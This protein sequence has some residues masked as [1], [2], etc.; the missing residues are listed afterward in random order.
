M[1]LPLL[2]LISSQVIELILATDLLPIYADWSLYT[3]EL[4][5][6][7][8]NGDRASCFNH[9]GTRILTDNSKARQQ[10]IL[11]TPYDANGG[12]TYEWTFPGTTPSN[13]I[14]W[15]ISFSKDGTKF[16]N[17]VTTSLQQYDCLSPWTAIWATLTGTLAW[18]N[19][20]AGHTAYS[21]CWSYD[22][23]KLYIWRWTYANNRYID[24]YTVST[25]WDI[26]TAVLAKSKLIDPQAYY[27][28]PAWIGISPDWDRFWIG[29]YTSSTDYIK[30][31][32]IADG[33]IN[34]LT[35]IGQ[36]V[37]ASMR[38]LQVVQ[39]EQTLLYQS[40]NYVYQYTID[41]NPLVALAWDAFINSWA[42]NTNYGSDPILY[43]RG[44]VWVPLGQ[45]NTYWAYL[46]FDL[47][48]KPAVASQVLL[49]CYATSNKWD[50]SWESLIKLDTDWDPNTITYANKP[51]QYT[52]SKSFPFSNGTMW[53]SLDI[54]DWYNAW[55]AWTYPNYWMKMS[56]GVGNWYYHTAIASSESANKPYLQIIE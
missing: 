55:Q 41:A 9:D 28:T 39:E 37:V 31:Y 22:E 42:V 48:N 8:F 20:T 45:A 26:N 4:W 6:T 53:K 5:P 10:H 32:G 50:N 30:Q 15:A 18:T 7:S 46:K 3:R 34:T 12:I 24:Q 33:D 52:W 13:T 49:W 44:W 14:A 2:Y 47:T 19:I 51:W 23:T 38:S 1:A 11:T 43:L 16:Y 36:E 54:T 27:F 40:A 29:V 21:F 17:N 56:W 25:P 35:Y